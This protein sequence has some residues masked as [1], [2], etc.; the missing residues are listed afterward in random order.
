MGKV[1]QNGQSELRWSTM[2]RIRL[3]KLEN[4]SATI[5]LHEINMGKFR[6]S[7]NANFGSYMVSE[8]WFWQFASTAKLHK[9]YQNRKAE[10]PKLSNDFTENLICRK[11]LKFSHCAILMHTWDDIRHFRKVDMSK[12]ELTEKPH[13]WQSKRSI[14]CLVRIEIRPFEG[15]W[16]SS[17][18]N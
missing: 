1:V 11:I 8:F 4:F 15:H 9:M 2:L 12:F 5:F 13:Y 3:V 16:Y 6:V 18:T 17:R 14:G 10:L 7:K